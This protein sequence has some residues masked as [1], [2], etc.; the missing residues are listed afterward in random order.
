MR[1]PTARPLTPKPVTISAWS[2]AGTFHSVLKMIASTTGTPTMTTRTM[3]TVEFT[4]VSLGY[5]ATSTT[6]G[7]S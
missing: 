2:A 4:Q 3:M 5:A 1:S 6:R 7:G